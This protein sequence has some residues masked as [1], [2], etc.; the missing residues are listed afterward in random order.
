MLKNVVLVANLA[1]DIPVLDMDY[2]GIDRGALRLAEQG[3]H[4]KFAIGDFDSISDAE[5]KLV[6]AFAEEVIQLNSMKDSSDSQIAIEECIERGY[7]NGVFYGAL[8]RRLDHQYVNQK[9]CMLDEFDCTCIDTFNKMYS[10]NKG[11]HTIDKLDYTYCSFF[12]IEDA[13]VTLEG[14]KYPLNE[15]FISTKNLIG[16]SN[17][18][19]DKHAVIHVLQG[20]VLCIQSKD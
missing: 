2:V 8:G 13:V 18:I 6:A 5:R 15:Y 17:E 12:A 20:K 14:F 1:E 16:L 11:S 7:T 19:L 3:I 10:L 4:M 9:L